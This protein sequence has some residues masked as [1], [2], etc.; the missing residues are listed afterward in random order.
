MWNGGWFSVF[1]TGSGGNFVAKLLL[2]MVLKELH[3]VID[4]LLDSDH[5]VSIEFMFMS[6]LKGEVI[7]LFAH[8][9]ELIDFG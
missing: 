8:F 5:R 7:K 2:L 3:E 6:L 1:V 9:F 4:F